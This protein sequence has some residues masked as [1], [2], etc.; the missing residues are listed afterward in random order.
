MAYYVDFLFQGDQGEIAE[1]VVGMLKALGL[2]PYKVKPSRGEWMLVVRVVSKALF[3]FLPSKKSLREDAAMRE[4]FFSGN[5]F[6]EIERGVLFVAG[7][8]DGD[9]TFTVSLDKSCSY[10][11]SVSKWN[12]SITQSKAK[13]M[14]LVE[15]AKRFV[16]SLVS[17]VGCGVTLKTV[18]T[19]GAV[20]ANF[21]KSASV[22]LLNLGIS[23]YSWKVAR[24]K[25]EVAESGRERAKY[26]TTGQVARIL[27]VDYRVVWR[28]VKS[29]KVRKIRRTLRTRRSPL[30][31]SRYYIPVDDVK[32]IKRK[33]R[34]DEEKVE[35]LKGKGMRL[36]DVSKMLGVP[37]T[38]LYRWYISGDLEATLIHEARGR[39]N[40]Y[41]VVPIE[42]VEKL[43][44][45]L[46]AKGGD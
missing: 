25:E 8:L 13:H 16:D 21:R 41:L 10:F 39:R 28:W 11:G 44:R 6:F 34:D 12:W 31:L 36:T 30:T 15:Y 46:E 26:F 37:H 5:G 2:T 42:K 32:K 40:T 24:W 29:G 7:L 9:G 20:R 18:P 14:F 45:K 19:K 43:R 23:K 22:A 3:S 17:G 33:F 4:R 1:K 27:N 35:K 38:T